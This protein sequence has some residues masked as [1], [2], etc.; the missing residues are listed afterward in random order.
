M[1]NAYN[2]IHPAF[3]MLM[4]TYT[5]SQG[6]TVGMNPCDKV[7]LHFYIHGTRFSKILI[8]IISEKI[9]GFLLSSLNFSDCMELFLQS[10]YFF[11]HKVT[12][13]YICTHYHLLASTNKDM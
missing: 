4:D 3:K 7:Y 2:G 8:V 6:K 10:L 5:N 12:W 13:S 1:V 9:T 11:S